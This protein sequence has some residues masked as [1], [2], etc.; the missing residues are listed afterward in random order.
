MNSTA[1]NL[2]FEKLAGEL[3]ELGDL[4]FILDRIPFKIKQEILW[5]WQNEPREE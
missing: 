2:E 4:D 3:L 1:L 5:A